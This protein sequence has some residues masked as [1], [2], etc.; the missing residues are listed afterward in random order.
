[1]ILPLLLVSFSLEARDPGPG[2]GFRIV[3][4]DTGQYDALPV[5]FPG[6]SNTVRQGTAA[7]YYRLACLSAHLRLYPLAMKLFLKSEWKR[8]KQARHGER[9]VLH[10]EPGLYPPEESSE[11]ETSGSWEITAREDS[12]LRF[13]GIRGLPSP[14][15]NIP[16]VLNAFRD[17][18]GASRYA[19]ILLVKQPVFKRRKVF[20]G[21]GNVGHTFITLIQFNRDNTYIS[22]TI[23]FYPRKRI[24][25]AA[26][27][28]IPGT[29]AV[30]RNDA[31]HDWDELVGR[32][33]SK[34]RF[35]DICRALEAYARRRYHL[36]RNNCTDFGL[37]LAGLGGICI[38]ETCSRWPLGS[39]NNPAC[40]GQS[41]LDGKICNAD[42]ENTEGLFVGVNREW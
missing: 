20:A 11:S 32:F 42:T 26:T 34:R 23:G 39:G 12:L 4:S 18:A 17:S 5:Y 36:S 3:L 35:R 30:F 8:Q 6:D 22:R 24:P 38:R 7:V 16:E 40:L 19:L 28:L 21:I 2:K 31:T 33:I 27:P 9:T 41:I 15:E 14:A 1:M 25:L 13:T 10:P 37:T 29:P